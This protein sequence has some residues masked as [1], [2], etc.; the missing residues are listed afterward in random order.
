MMYPKIHEIILENS[1]ERGLMDLWPMD[2]PNNVYEP[3]PDGT[4]GPLWN[5][6]CELPSDGTSVPRCDVKHLERGRTVGGQQPDGSPRREHLH[7]LGPRKSINAGRFPHDAYNI[8]P[9]RRMALHNCHADPSTT[10]DVAAAATANVLAVTPKFPS[11][12]TCTSVTRRHRRCD[13]APCGV[14]VRSQ[15]RG[16]QTR[17]M[18]RIALEGIQEG[19]QR[20]RLAL[21]AAVQPHSGIQTATIG[22]GKGIGEILEDVDATSRRRKLTSPRFTRTYRMW[23][24]TG[25][26]SFEYGKQRQKERGAGCFR[27]L[28]ACRWHP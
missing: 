17:S 5:N 23:S 4:D 16:V 9:G 10:V 26:A 27:E 14:E 13:L 22:K 11:T 3:S 7:P 8:S 18:T 21:G 25:C 19:E 6:G 24:A 28:R 1:P 2:R 12:Y 15:K 20:H